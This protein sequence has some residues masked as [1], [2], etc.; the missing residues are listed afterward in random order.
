M[1]KTINA[2]EESILERLSNFKITDDSPPI[3]PEWIKDKIVDINGTL[4][5]EEYAGFGVVNEQFYQKIECNEVECMSTT[6][7]VNGISITK[8]HDIY[9]VR[10]PYLQ[11]GIGQK[12]I[13]Y[14]GLS[15]WRKNFRRTDL[16]GLANN[17][18]RIYTKLSPAYCLIGHEF[19][20]VDLP[21]T[22]TKRLGM[23]VVLA[24]PRTAPKWD[25]AIT[26]FPTPSTYKLE[27]LVFQDAVQAF[28]LVPDVLDDA[29]R[30]RGGAQSQRPQQSDQSQ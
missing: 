20:I 10:A 14:L 8:K 19:F 5:R 30:A 11:V 13:M 22:S 26:I 21:T 16:V 28:N 2:L 4:M 9:K 6:C 25:D 1:V 23:M 18:Y 12:D 27:M 7:V 17:Q 3:P 15:S 24:D 29:Q